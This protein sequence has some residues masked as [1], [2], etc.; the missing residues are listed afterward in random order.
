[1]K[2]SGHQKQ[3]ETFNLIPLS[4][5]LSLHLMKVGTGEAHHGERLMAKKVIVK[6]RTLLLEGE[7]IFSTII[8]GK[9]G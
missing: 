6:D 4:P 1:M 5:F 7:C 3:K 2:V 8:V 9:R